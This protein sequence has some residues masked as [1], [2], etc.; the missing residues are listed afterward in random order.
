[1]R[2]PEAIVWD[3][4]GTLID[5]APDMA[6]ALNNMLDKRGFAGHSLTAVRAM[7]GNGA[8]KLVERA[9]NTLGVRLEATNQ[10][11]LVALFL[12]EYA[13][14]ATR[15]TRPY[16]LVIEVLE[17]IH[18]M[19]IPMGVCTNKPEAIS[20]H[21]LDELGLSGYFSSVIGGDTTS[22]R[23]PDP[24]PLLACLKELVAKPQ[25]SLMIGDSSIDVNAARAAD[26]CVGLVPWGYRHEPVENLGADFII[27]D[28]SALPAMLLRPQQRQQT[29]AH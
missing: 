3:L 29:T 27:H 8:A 13:A 28:L 16:P 15:L 4:D 9:F 24:L 5:S 19:N 12:Q 10:E 11:A 17:Q 7:I 22:A 20:R 14:C 25:T 26:V 6:T 2:Y 21:I 1:M 18:D 23:K